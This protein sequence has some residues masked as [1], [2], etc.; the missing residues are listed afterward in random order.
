MAKARNAQAAMRLEDIPNIGPSIA[1]DLRAL[2]IYEPAQLVGQD[3]YQLYRRM[4]EITGV[5]HDP[6]LC[7]TF[8][9]AVRFMEGGPSRPWWYFT[10]ERKARLA[11]QR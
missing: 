8:I 6:C 3:P 9:A 1:D 7:D 11:R 2:D 10:P 4:G 5:A